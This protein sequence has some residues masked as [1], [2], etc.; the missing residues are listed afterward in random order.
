MSGPAAGVSRHVS[1]AR[2]RRLAGAAIAMLLVV[3][4]TATG[5]TASGAVRAVGAGGLVCPVRGFTTYANTWGAPRSGGR[6]H[7]GVDLMA[8]TGTPLVA[9]TA[10][11]VRFWT[12]RLGGRVASLT[13]DNGTRYYY[14]HLSTYA[15]WSRRVDRGEVIGYVGSTGNAG[16]PHLHFE[17][18]PGGGAAV[19]PYAHVLA[20]G[21]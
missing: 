11:H 3:G 14:A 13:A 6:T 12:N 19:S 7:E 5:A 17:V 10:G 21:C 16:A 18:H 2:S 20:A 8:P 15:G 1:G 9:V 4:A